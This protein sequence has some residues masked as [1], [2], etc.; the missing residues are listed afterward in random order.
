MYKFL[1]IILKFFYS[2]FRA[3]LIF[4]LVILDQ[5]WEGV[6]ERVVLTINGNN[7]SPPLSCRKQNL[8]ASLTPNYPKFLCLS[9]RDKTLKVDLILILSFPNL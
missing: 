4:C 9:G 7:P 6:D 2:R 5:G 8:V 1:F 3:K